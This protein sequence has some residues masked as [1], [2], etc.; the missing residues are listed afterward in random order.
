MNNRIRILRNIKYINIKHTINTTPNKSQKTH[1]QKPHHT[2]MRGSNK[3][4]VF[5]VQILHNN[6]INQQK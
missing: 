1:A 4:I 3:F 6:T 2:N 5:L